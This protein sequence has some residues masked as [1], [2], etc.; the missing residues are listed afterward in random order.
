M[1]LSKIK[2]V[3]KVLLLALGAALLLRLVGTKHGFPFIYHP[4]EPAVVRSATGVLFEPN[5]GHFDW[6]HMF[7]YMNTLVYF[8]FIKFRGLLQILGF[9]S[10][11]EPVIPLFWRDPLVFYYISRVFSALLGAFTLI[12]IYLTGKQLF[13]RRVALLAAGSFAVIPFHV[14]HSHYALVDVPMTFWVAWALYF[15]SKIYKNY[16]I[17]NYIWAGVFIGFAASTKYNGGL[18]AVVVL[19]AHFLRV[20]KA[21]NEKFISGDSIKR[22]VISGLF[23]IAAFIFGT[24]YA[25]LDSDTFLRSDSPRGAL[26]QFKNVGKVGFVLQFQQLFKNMYTKLTDDFGYTFLAVYVGGVL[27]SVGVTFTTIKNKT[28]KEF[29]GGPQSKLLL[30]IIPSLFLFWYISGF[31]KTRSHYYMATYPFVALVVGYL[32]SQA[33]SVVN[34]GKNMRYFVF[35]AFFLL[36]FIISVQKTRLFL[37]GDTRNVLYKWML[38]NV[39]ESDLII[40]DDNDA[41][42]VVEKFSKNEVQKGVSE[43]RVRFGTGI[44][45]VSDDSLEQ[46]R[47]LQPQGSDYLK[48]VKYINSKGRL[49]PHI[50]IFEFG[51][52][53]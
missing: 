16:D 49:G 42:Q 13:N 10:F 47:S 19:L 25:L 34:F 26:W 52:R 31:G 36:P 8:V 4:D 23:S 14:W 43:D 1:T 24:P 22:L 5:P 48:L 28:L 7:F 30:L 44:V 45:I 6:P 35:A 33:V 40:Y 27:Y 3:D 11:L 46:L 17:K 38:V 18:I 37:M 51:E 39:R 21:Q 20:Y 12:P 50:E 9:R 15:S 29:I 2:N 41:I 32:I 53:Q